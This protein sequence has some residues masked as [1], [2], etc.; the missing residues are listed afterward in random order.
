MDFLYPTL[1]SWFLGYSKDYT[2]HV[3][4]FF[5]YI[6]LYVLSIK[7]VILLYFITGP[8]KSHFL[9]KIFVHSMYQGCGPEKCTQLV[10]KI[11]FNM[12]GHSATTMK[13]L[14]ILPCSSGVWTIS[15][16]YGGSLQQYTA[17]FEVKDYGKWKVER[18]IDNWVQ[19]NLQKKIDNT[20]YI[21]Q[22]TIG[23]RNKTIAK[24][25]ARRYFYWRTR[26]WGI[27]LSTDASVRSIIL[28]SD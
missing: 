22:T 1:D 12:F 4:V 13:L 23:L 21:C 3:F 19:E 2:H 28:L 9:R 8:L 11:P 27:H 16:S 18:D 7:F 6:C 17:H 25:N 10:V 5:I 14:Y 26:Q 20:H 24:T 15:A